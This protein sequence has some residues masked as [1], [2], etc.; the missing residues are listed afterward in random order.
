M[1]VR[2]SLCVCA[3]VCV[4]ACALMGTWAFVTRCPDWLERAAGRQNKTASVPEKRWQR[5]R[6]VGERSWEDRRGPGW[7]Q[8]R[9]EAR[10]LFFLRNNAG[11]LSDMWPQ[12]VDKTWGPAA[13]WPNPLPHPRHKNA[14][15]LVRKTTGAKRWDA[16]FFFP[17]D[18]LLERR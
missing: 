5:P 7:D 13:N 15:D 18:W 12:L 4:C 10:R 9:A 1:C 3:P 11:R 2:V 8:H 6:T 14:S 17:L 16:I